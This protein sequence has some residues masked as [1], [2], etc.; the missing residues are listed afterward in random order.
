MKAL[1]QNPVLDISIIA[2]MLDLKTNTASALVKDFV[3]YNVLY[4]MTGRQRNR[5]FWFKE[6]MMIFSKTN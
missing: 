2:S 5:I 3:N 4:E 1:Y 6:Y